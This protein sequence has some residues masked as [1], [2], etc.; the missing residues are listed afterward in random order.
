MEQEASEPEAPPPSFRLIKQ[1]LL[2]GDTM[3][4]SLVKQMLQNHFRTCSDRSCSACA[5]IRKRV[6]NR[7]ERKKSLQRR[8]RIGA[9]IAGVLSLAH[10][11]ATERA[12]APGGL[13]YTVACT[14]FEASARHLEPSCFYSS[15]SEEHSRKHNP[16]PADACADCAGE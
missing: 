7:R 15:E 8:F 3:V 14:S 12:Y 9:R 5:K 2:D 6:D 1:R 13:G 16:A 11:R 10:A 4:L